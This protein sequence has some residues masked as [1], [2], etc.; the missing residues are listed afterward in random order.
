MSSPTASLPTTKRIFNFNAGPATLPLPVL[1]RIREE[2]FDWRGS[3]M[4]VMEM[5]H[6]SPEYESINAAAGQKL[7]LRMQPGYDHSYFCITSFIADHI[8]WH[9]QRLRGT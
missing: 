8:A 2:L 4:S 1:E 3:G 9:A 6:R 5:S 7:T